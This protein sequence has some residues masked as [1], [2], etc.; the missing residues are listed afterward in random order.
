MQHP[1]W[2]NQYTLATFNNV[3]TTHRIT[4]SDPGEFLT[5]FSSFAAQ[6]SMNTNTTCTDL[7][8]LTTLYNYLYSAQTETYGIY[9]VF[10][11]GIMQFSPIIYDQVQLL[12]EATQSQINFVEADNYPCGGSLTDTGPQLM[13]SLATMTGGQVFIVSLPNAAGAMKTIPLKFSSGLIYEK[14]VDDCTP[15]AFPNGVDF[16]FPIDSETQTFNVLIDADL[17]RD[18]IYTYPNGT[19]DTNQLVTNIFTDYGVST[20]LD[21]VIA[22][23]DKFYRNVENRCWYLSPTLATWSDAQAACANDGAILATVFDNNIEQYLYCKFL[24]NH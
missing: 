3:T 6:N 2:I 22:P 8:I 1:R 13:W 20:R 10:M 9:Y 4:T 16:Y 12:L 11:R 21:Q 14:Y 17:N 5:A 18:P 24:P 19:Q 7:P 23:C 15:K